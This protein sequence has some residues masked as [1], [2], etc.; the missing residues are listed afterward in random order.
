M[1]LEHSVTLNTMTRLGLLWTWKVYF[2]W[3]VSIFNSLK[4]IDEPLLKS[5]GLD[6][7]NWLY[8]IHYYPLPEDYRNVNKCDVLFVEASSA[9]MRFNYST[10]KHNRYITEEEAGTS[11]GYRTFKII[12][13]FAG[14]VV[15][16]HHDFESYMPWAALLPEFQKEMKY[17]K[18]LEEVSPINFRMISQWFRPFQDKEWTILNSFNNVDY[19]LDYVI[20]GQ[21]TNRKLV[22]YGY[23]VGFYH[24]PEPHT[25]ISPHL[26]IKPSPTFD[27]TWCGGEWDSSQRHGKSIYSRVE[28][29]LR[30]YNTN[31][32]KTRVVGRWT[33]PEIFDKTTYIPRRQTAADGMAYNIFNDCYATILVQSRACTLSGKV[34]GRQTMAL[35]G[36]ALLIGDSSIFEHVPNYVGKDFTVSSPE[37][38]AECIRRIKSMTPEE[39]EEVRMTQLRKFPCFT[40]LPWESVIFKCKGL[41][42]LDWHPETQQ[43]TSW[44]DATKQNY[45]RKEGDEGVF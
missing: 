44:Y 13:Q 26:P 29:V 3:E 15:Y 14:R 2:G 6:G 36:G 20:R 9:N 18:P 23:P 40:D 17:T 19:F 30:Y 34:Q 4:P 21:A 1:S 35:H 43:F 28:G 33:N 37:E 25:Q 32:Y 27:A 10:S 38:V 22:D 31:L 45:G 24:T 12:N 41:Q 5:R 8:G 11:Y 39:R 42:G 7:S 16:Y